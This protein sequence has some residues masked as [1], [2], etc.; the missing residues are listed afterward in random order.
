MK[1][2]LA[3][4]LIGTLGAGIYFFTSTDYKKIPDILK[5]TKKVVFQKED[6]SETLIK[7]VEDKYADELIEKGW[8]IRKQ[9]FGKRKSANKFIETPYDLRIRVE[10]SRNGEAAYL[11]DLANG[12]VLPIYKG[13]QVGS[14][15][16]RLGGLPQIVKD[17]ISNVFEQ[18][19]GYTNDKID[20]LLR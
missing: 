9:L 17:K 13:I 20:E 3:T 12:K 6:Y 10:H 16:H 15:E 4:I 1:K 8:E 14:L 5:I 11:I 19:K 18:A 2:F 7:E